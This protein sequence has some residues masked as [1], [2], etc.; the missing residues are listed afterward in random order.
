LSSSFFFYITLRKKKR[1][2]FAEKNFSLS[3]NVSGKLFAQN[4]PLYSNAF[5]LFGSAIYFAQLLI[6]T[7]HE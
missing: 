2:G 3:I 7:T 5:K 6:T 4:N 1:L